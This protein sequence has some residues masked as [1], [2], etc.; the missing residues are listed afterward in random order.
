MTINALYRFRNE[1]YSRT[2]VS[3]AINYYS[4]IEAHTRLAVL[5][6]TKQ[7]GNTHARAYVTFQINTSRSEC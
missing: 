5:A 1:I 2:I 7:S 4:D 6:N 3:T